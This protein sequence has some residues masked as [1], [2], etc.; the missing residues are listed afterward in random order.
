MEPFEAQC[1][2]YSP[3]WGHAD[4]YRF[5]LSM[6][7][8]EI[9]HGPRSRVAVWRDNM[10]PEWEGHDTVGD[11]MRNDSIYPPEHVEDLLSYV[12]KSWRDGQLTNEQ[13]QAELNA[14]VDYLNAST[15]NKPQTDFWHGIF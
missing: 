15:A 8:F 11:I 7:K 10:D 12:W 5:I 9:F 2:V 1:Q 6:E 3:R 4:T 13:A 14:F